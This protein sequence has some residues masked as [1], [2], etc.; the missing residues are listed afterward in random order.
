MRVRWKLV[1]AG[2]A[3]AVVLFAPLLAGTSPRRDED[4]LIV[5]GHIDLPETLLDEFGNRLGRVDLAARRKPGEPPRHADIPRMREGRLG[6]FFSIAYVPSKVTGPQAATAMLEQIDVTRRL[7]QRYPEHLALATTAEQLEAVHRSGRIAVLIGIE[8]GH[9]I[10][11]SLAVLRAAYECGARYLTL[12]HW[13]P[14]DW[15]DAA[16]SPP[17]HGGLTPF[18]REVLREM[19]RLGMMIDLSHVS[20]AVMRDA[21]AVSAAPVIFSHS[22]A[23]ALCQHARNVPDDVL[24]LVKA[25]RGIVMVNFAPGFVSEAVRL[26]ELPLESEWARLEALHPGNPAKVSEGI[27]TWRATHPIP[28]ATLAQVADHIGHIRQVAG[29][30]HVGI[31]SDFEGIGSTPDGLADVSRYPALLE[32]LSRRG[33]SQEEV[34]KV[35]GGNFLRVMQEVEAVAARL[36][37]ERP[38]SEAAIGDFPA[39]PPLPATPAPTPA[40]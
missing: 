13:G 22:S 11:N 27:Q 19:N 1:L 23:R 26:A 32:E 21:M 3:V 18:G 30:D 24:A 5:D 34:R 17:R 2:V 31:G 36:Q 12:T 40:P 4:I 37:K 14:T 29:I 25:N 9:T 28:R 38:P 35:A 16:T 7:V 10:A 8:G 6:A 39:A 15:A 33:Y 20:D